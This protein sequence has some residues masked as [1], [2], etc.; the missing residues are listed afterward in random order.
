MPGVAASRSPAAAEDLLMDGTNLFFI[1]L[2]AWMKANPH[3]KFD[4]FCHA[5][6]RALGLLAKQAASRGESN[7]R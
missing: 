6:H 7:D 4:E 5:M 2:W 3:A 1:A